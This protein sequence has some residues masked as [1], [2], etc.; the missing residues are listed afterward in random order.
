MYA[1]NLL[2]HAAGLLGKS[3]VLN[4]PR[5]PW[6]IGMTTVSYLSDSLGLLSGEASSLIN[7]M[8]FDEDYVQRQKQI[9]QQKQIEPHGRG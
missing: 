6:R 4:L 3:S 7:A 2:T 8:A 5:V 9:R 1:V